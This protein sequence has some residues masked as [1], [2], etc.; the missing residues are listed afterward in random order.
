MINSKRVLAA[1]LVAA[2]GLTAAA[3]GDDDD[4]ATPETEAPGDTSADTTPATEPAATEPAGTEPAGTCRHRRVDPR[5]AKLVVGPP[6]LRVG[7]DFVRFLGFLEMFLGLGIVRIA[8]RMP[9]HGELAV[10][11]LD[12][13]VGR[14]TWDAEHGIE[15][16]HGSY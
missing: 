8:V 12:V 13:V 11:L 16:G 5:M 7:Q 10:R 15:I 14:V 3:C 9:F 4:E 1:A 2:L 6:F